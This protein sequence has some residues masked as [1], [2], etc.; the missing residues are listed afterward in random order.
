MVLPW[1]CSMAF[2]NI[3]QESIYEAGLSM[4]KNSLAQEAQTHS[5]ENL[6]EINLL[7]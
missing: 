3:S 1:V 7:R 4:L 2:K 5:P 6:I